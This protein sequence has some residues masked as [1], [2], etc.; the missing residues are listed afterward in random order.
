MYVYKGGRLSGIILQLGVALRALT[1]L[2]M[3]AQAQD[4]LL[5]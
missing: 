4:A 1:G 5:G 3:Q 2:Q